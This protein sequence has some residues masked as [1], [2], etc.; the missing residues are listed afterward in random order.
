MRLTIKTLVA[1]AA[2]TL[3]LAAPA[4]A[5]SSEHI[6]RFDDGLSPAAQQA[7]VQGAGGKVT[8]DLHIID[9]VG[10]R[11]SDAAAR[12]LAADSRVASIVADSPVQLSSTVIDSSVLGT[13]FNASMRTDKLWTLGGTGK[14]VTVAVVDTGIAGNLPD[15]QVSRTDTTSRV[16]ASVVT[17]PEATTATDTFGH[18]T[19]VAGLIAGNGSNRSPDDPQYG[20]YAGTAPDANLVSIKV[21]DDAGQTSVLDVIYGVQFAVDHKSEYGIRVLNLSL[22]STTAMSYKEDPLDAAVEQAW[23]KGIAVVTAA[24]NRGASAPDAVSYAPANDPYVITVGAANDMGTKLIQD[25]VRAS[26]SSQGRT[27]D[28]VAKPDVAAPGAGLVAPL[29]P[30]SAFAAQCPTC[31]VGGS[32]LRIGGTSMAAA[33]TSGAVAELLQLH[34][35]WT[36]DMVKAALVK[37]AREVAGAGR[38]VN[39]ASADRAFVNDPL[40]Q[41]ANQ[42]LTPNPIVNPVTGEIDFTRAS[43]SRAS[44]ST[45]ADL[46]RASWSRASWSC[47]CW[48]TDEEIAA[49]PTRASWSRASWS[50]ASWSFSPDL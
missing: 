15:F 42:G 40:L 3:G 41:P 49:D 5:A 22:N 13:A 32:Y 19:H 29:A 6:V 10:A 46:L 37:T 35:N 34:P 12:R 11:L 50:R 31:V 1:A 24:G 39:A 47:A 43:W 27:Q 45:A 25:D 23:F 28:G 14:G 18:G 30:N 16:I 36:P 48:A 44:W 7:V 8:R 4:P 9:G 38:I 20:K 21:S 2:A 17:N 33:V 26:W